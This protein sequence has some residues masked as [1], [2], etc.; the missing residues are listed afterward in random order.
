MR[1]G[2]QITGEGITQKLA[3]KMSLPYGE[4]KKFPYELVI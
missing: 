2:L 4:G 1:D 3:T